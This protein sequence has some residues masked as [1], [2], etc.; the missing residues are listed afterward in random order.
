MTACPGLL[1]RTAGAAR[2]PALGLLL[3]CLLAQPLPA[4]DIPLEFADPAMQQRYL[5][6]LEELRCLVCQNQSLADSNAP[7]AQD[8]RQEVFALIDAGAGDREI[9]DFLVQRYGDFVLY[10]PPLRTGTMLLWIGPFILLLIG[11]AVV[12][13]IALTGKGTEPPALSV[14]EQRRLRELLEDGRPR[15]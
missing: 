5:T 7:L 10:R 3:F 15:S 12:L 14:E 13:R 4:A 2:C 8:L 9:L 1:R 6:L 11:I